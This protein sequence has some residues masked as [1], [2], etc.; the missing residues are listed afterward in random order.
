[1]R[2]L[3]S[4]KE[5]YEKVLSSKSFDAI[6]YYVIYLDH[7]PNIVCTV[8][9]TPEVDFTGNRLQT[10]DLSKPVDMLTCSIVITEKGAAVVFAWLLEFNQAC[11]RFVHSLDS[12]KTHL[13]P[14]AIVRLTFE[15]GENL[16]FTQSWWNGLNDT[17]KVKL[18]GRAN[19][20]M[21]KPS[22]CL[23]DDNIRPVLWS[24]I[25]REMRLGNN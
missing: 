22:N 1:M 4:Q 18:E 2:D 7:V 5:A 3:A 25:G 20:L 6:S 21:D 14:S 8:G 24:V 17:V 13:L 11:T 9:F 10:Y 12:M 23:L 19:S 16:F 15:H